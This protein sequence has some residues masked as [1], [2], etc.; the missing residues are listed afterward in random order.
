MGDIFQRVWE[1][2]IR[3]VIGPMNFRIIIQPLV[4]VFFAIRSGM[5][6]ARAGRSAFLWT[7]LTDKSQRGGLLRHAWSD[8]GKVFV[9]ACIL[10]AIYQVIVHRVVYIL[11]MLIVAAVLAVLPYIIIRGPVTRLVARLHHHHPV[12]QNR[13]PQGEQHVK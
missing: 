9:F 12:P 13:T 3:R 2:L 7:A 5:R 8:V 4:A 11:E 6:D 10:D 1:N